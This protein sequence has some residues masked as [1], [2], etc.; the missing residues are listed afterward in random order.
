[1]TVLT[2]AEEF[3]KDC[4]K[5]KELVMKSQ[6]LDEISERCRGTKVSVRFSGADT[7]HIV[8]PLSIDFIQEDI[9]DCLIMINEK[10]DVEIRNICSKYPSEMFGVVDKAENAD[11]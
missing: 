2:K 10:L 7:E 1:M 8:C 9:N 11:D 6:L 5:L 3:E 4:A